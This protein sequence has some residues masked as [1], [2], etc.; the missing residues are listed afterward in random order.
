MVLRDHV[1][2]VLIISLGILSTGISMF[3]SAYNVVERDIAT[4]YSVKKSK[5]SLMF[6]IFNIVYL[7]IAPLLFPIIKKKY[8]CFVH[9]SIIFVFVG[10]IGRYLCRG[11]YVAAIVWTT[12]V[13]I[14]NVVI[15]TAP[16]GLMPLFNPV[17]RG[18]A[19]SIAIFLPLVGHNITAMYAFGHISSDIMLTA[20]LN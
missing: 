16:F 20:E 5:I 19:M 9:F 11:A 2:W 15:V 14:A 4:Y 6:N 1:K 18:Y 12:L 8:M 3:I 17:K 13:A 7:I 10:S